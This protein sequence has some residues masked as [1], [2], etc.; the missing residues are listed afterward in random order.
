VLRAN[1]QW[2]TIFPNDQQMGKVRVDH[3]IREFVEVFEDNQENSSVRYGNVGWKHPTNKL[4]FMTYLIT[5]GV[6]RHHFDFVRW[7]ACQK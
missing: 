5:A 3:Q 2:M 1:E 6:K 4:R 7:M